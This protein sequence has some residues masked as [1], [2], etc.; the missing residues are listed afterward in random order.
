MPRCQVE[1]CNRGFDSAPRLRRH[2][3]IHNKGEC[4]EINCLAVL[5]CVHVSHI[6]TLERR[7]PFLLRHFTMSN[8]RL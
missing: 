1:G 5:H 2:M 7:Y 3:K 8:G 4:D 6:P